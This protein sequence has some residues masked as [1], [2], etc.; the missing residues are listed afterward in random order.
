MA[1]PAYA[2]MDH[3]SYVNNGDSTF[4]TTQMVAARSGG[5][6]GGR[7]SAVMRAPPRPSTMNTRVIERTTIVRPSPVIVAPPVYGYGYGYNP[8]PGLGRF[9]SH[10]F[11][12]I[13]L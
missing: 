2:V 11:G 10:E 1:D 4:G 7:S 13:I 5:R 6:A 12:N 8:V 3:S 9:S